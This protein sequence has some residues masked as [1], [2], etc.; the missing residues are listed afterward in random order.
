MSN[1]QS[2]QE[3]HLAKLGLVYIKDMCLVWHI[4]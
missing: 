3:T 1:A 4:T 2:T